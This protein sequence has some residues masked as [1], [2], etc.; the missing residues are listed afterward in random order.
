MLRKLRK[1]RRGGHRLRLMIASR[2]VLELGR[3]PCL[4]Q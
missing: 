2:L 4:P 1:R 3:V